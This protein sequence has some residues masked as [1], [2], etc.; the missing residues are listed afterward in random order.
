MNLTKKEIATIYLALSNILNGERSEK[1]SDRIEKIQCKLESEMNKRND[2]LF[3]LQDLGFGKEYYMKD[4]Y[5][6]NKL[7]KNQT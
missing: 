5:C 2:S 6:W 3:E 4:K 7:L 1:D